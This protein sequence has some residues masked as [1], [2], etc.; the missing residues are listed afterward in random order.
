MSVTRFSNPPWYFSPPTITRLLRSAGFE[1]VLATTRGLG[2]EELRRRETPEDHTPKDNRTAHRTVDGCDP[3][4]FLQPA[5]D[6]I[7]RTFYGWGLGENVLVGGAS[8]GPAKRSPMPWPRICEYLVFY[9]SGRAVLFR[10]LPQAEL[11]KIV[12]LVLW[13]VERMDRCRRN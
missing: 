11:S 8:A 5:K 12:K 9:W 6:A 1:L 2:L 10:P 13:R 3:I 7:K 4:S